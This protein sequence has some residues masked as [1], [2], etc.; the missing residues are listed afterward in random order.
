MS[1]FLNSWKEHLEISLLALMISTLIGMILGTLSTKYS[2]SEKWITS[3]FQTLRIIPSLAILLLLLPIMGTGIR[4][5]LVALIILGIPPILMNTVSGLQSVS[6]SLL[7]SAQGV[8]MSERQIRWK[9][10]FPV[11]GPLILTGIKTAAIEIIASATLA[12]KL[13]QD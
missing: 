1:T 5:A 7:E 12:T 6:M 8:G 11:A 4:P 3:L 9:I 13:S 2:R 10:Q